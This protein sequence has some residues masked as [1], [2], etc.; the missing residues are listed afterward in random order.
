MCGIAGLSAATPEILAEMQARL[1]HR[2]PDGADRFVC[3]M[4][5]FG[6]AH[7]RLAVIDLTE[8]GRQP[9]ASACGR[10]VI[11]FN[12]EIYNHAELRAELEARGQSFRSTSDTEVLLALLM[13]HGAAAL[14]RLV[15][16]FAFALLDRQTGSV[17]LARDRV[18]IKPL[19]WA[20]RPRP[21]RVASRSAAASGVNEPSSS[22][23]WPRTAAVMAE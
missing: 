3:D 6:L 20:S 1:A 8:G 9:M 5:G 13:T 17:L 16:M 15:G 7:T 22:A 12:G 21:R 19:V 14:D 4:T 2:G 10:W 18:G 23:T 11:T